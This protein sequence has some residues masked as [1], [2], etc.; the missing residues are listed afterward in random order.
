[1]K[2]EYE[3][4]YEDKCWFNGICPRERTKGCSSICIMR[5]EFDY[6]LFASAVPE[7]YKTYSKIA[8]YAEDEDIGTFSTLS[9]IKNDIVS[10]VDEGR[11]LYLWGVHP[12]AGRTSWSIKIMLTYLAYKC[13]GNG[14]NPN[15]AYFVYVPN[16]L[17]SAK[18][19]DDKEKRQEILDKVMNVDL[20]VLDDLS[21]TQ[22][23]KYDE[24]VLA[25]VID[26]RYREGKSTIFNSNLTPDELEKTCG[27]RTTDRILSDIVLEIKGGGYRESTNKY[28]RKKK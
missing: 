20:L 28:E 2:E 14:F 17:F 19:F 8:L 12:G 27:V 6:L 25:D 7:K 5:R 11:F 18:N 16:F 23:T 22:T 9:N 13:L 4:K 10:F 1:M 3:Y 24:S 15:V 21:A 26:Y